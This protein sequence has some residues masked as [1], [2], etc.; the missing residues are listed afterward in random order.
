MRRK[1]KEITDKSKIEAV[2]A[3]A[4]VCRLAIVD[5][6]RPYIVPLC[7]GYQ[8]D[9]LY[10]HSANT[11]KK[12][13]LLHS[14]N[15]VCF[16]LDVD[17]KIISG[18][19]PCNWGMHYQSVIGHGRAEFLEDPAAK[20]RALDIIMQQYTGADNAFEYDDS[21]L[22]HTVVFQVR[23]ASMTAKRSG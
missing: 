11:G 22:G 10:F 6:N 23:V 8:D 12:L 4:T 1:D 14:N 9:M 15:R 20:R 21:A 19:K 5:G 18:D 7:F 3:R 2:I 13:E 17:C 16:E